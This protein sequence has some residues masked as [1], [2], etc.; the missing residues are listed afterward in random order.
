MV[1]GLWKSNA[2]ISLTITSQNIQDLQ[3]MTWVY[4]NHLLAADLLY[5]THHDDDDQSLGRKG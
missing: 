2:N 1:Q 4:E 3:G 5:G